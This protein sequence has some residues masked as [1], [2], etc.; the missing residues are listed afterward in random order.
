MLGFKAHGVIDLGAVYDVTDHAG[1]TVGLFRKDF[2]Q[3][4][5]RSTRHVEQPDLGRVTGQER[6]AA[7]GV[8][9]R[10]IE[11]LSF[12]PYRF[13][14]TLDGQTVFF[15]DKRWGLRDRYTIDIHRPGVG[16]RLAIAMAVA[17]DALQGR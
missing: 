1:A 11:A 17:L 8:L 10:F 4:L 5:L 16:R 3:S 15:V 14:F 2:K 9:R 7:I 12:V 13:A 6:N